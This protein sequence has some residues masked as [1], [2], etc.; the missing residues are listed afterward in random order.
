MKSLWREELCVGKHEEF[1]ITKKN[2]AKTFVQSFEKIS[3]AIIK[4]GLFH[5][6]LFPFDPSITD[7][8]KCLG[9]ENVSTSA[10]VS[11]RL[12]TA[13][14]QHP[15]VSASAQHPQVTASA[16]H[17]LVAAQLSPSQDLEIGLNQP[18]MLQDEIWFDQDDWT[19]NMRI[20]EEINRTS[21]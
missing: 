9:K 19:H 13:S 5:T 1:S 17:L 8:K 4:N 10:P 3:A 7:F 20:F 15:L 11:V 16:Q 12:S 21:A 14:A 18:F 2:F 6:G